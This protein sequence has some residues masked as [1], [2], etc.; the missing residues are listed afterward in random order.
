MSK[1]IVW[2]LV[3]LDGYFEGETKWDLGFHNYAWGEDLENLSKD[4]GSRTRLLVFGRITYEGMKSYWTTTEEETE[5]KAYMNALPKL[6]ASR[7]LKASD[8]NN[9]RMTDDVVGELRRLKAEPGKDIYIFGSAE[10]TRT[11]LKEGLV[12]ELMIGVVPVLLGKG[13]HFFKEGGVER[14]FS[15]VEARP[16]KNGTVILRY[17]PL[18]A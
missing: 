15:L 11:L 18:A 1:V 10:L 3:T 6:V 14:R 5:V 9:T 13:T 4:F 8:W 2:N 17:Q 16:L 12:D 7:T